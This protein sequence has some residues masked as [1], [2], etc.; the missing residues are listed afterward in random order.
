MTSEIDDLYIIA[1]AAQGY[2]GSTDQAK[3][4]VRAA[5][6][7]KSHAIK[8]QIVY[9]TDLCEK[10]YQYHDLF[11][12]LE[13]SL[14]EWQS[15][16]DL[17]KKNH[18]D[19]I[20]D[21]FGPR[22]LE[23]GTEINCD[24]YKLHSTTFFDEELASQ[25]FQ[26]KKPTYISVGGI[27]PDEIDDFINRNKLKKRDDVT[28]LYGFQ[29]EPTPIDANNLSRI[30]ALE[31]HTGLK[32]GFMDHSEGSGRHS[33]TLSAMALGMGVR[34]FEKHI[35]L[36]RSL[37]LEDY[38]SALTPGEFKHYVE[39]LSELVKAYGNPDITLSESE[40]TY[41]GKALKRVVAARDLEA[42]EVLTRNDIRLSRPASPG[43]EYKLDAV[44]SRKL[45]SSIKQGMPIE[46]NDLAKD[47]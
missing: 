4:L 2:E 14:D 11:K 43:G 20:V 38:V 13:M 46:L 27:E 24:G 42:G 8:F 6:A 7:A 47:K 5:A 21:V 3:L 16:R 25:V 33:M 32:V 19:F 1:E 29:A 36:D 9:V 40:R 44:T 23:I 10:G 39:M 45:K 22:S 12:Q 41:R 34:L 18:L 37:E 15:I 31:Q 30:S 26:Q 28:I 35:T 17:S